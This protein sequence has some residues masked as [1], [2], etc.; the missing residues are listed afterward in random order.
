LLEPGPFGKYLIGGAHWIDADSSKRGRKGESHLFKRNKIHVESHG[1]S[2]KR[3]RENKG[4]N[5]HLKCWR[6][7][8][9]RHQNFKTGMTALL[10]EQRRRGAQIAA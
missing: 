8:A 4:T 9:G 3:K 1:E 7:Q 10:R 2:A 6:Q 5:D